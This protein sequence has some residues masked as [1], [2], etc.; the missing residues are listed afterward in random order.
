M[1]EGSIRPPRAERRLRDPARTR[2][3]ILSTAAAEF[4]RHGFGGGRV[5]RIARRARAN[6]RMIYHYF[7]NKDGLYLAVLERVYAAKR[8]AERALEVDH[9]DPEAA[10]RALVDFNFAY[11]QDHPEF[12]AL[13]N[14]EN[15]QRARHL[16]R[17]RL[18]KDLYSPVVETLRTV[19]REGV[20][21]GM[22]RNDVDPVHLYITIVGLPY[23]Y[24]G[25]N[26]TLSTIFDRSLAA[27]AE[28]ARYRAHAG[29]VML[30]FLRAPARAGRSQV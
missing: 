13:L 21:R 10:I 11:C 30:G 2:G 27:A 25:N 20:R 7:G 24:V 5:D 3:A 15:L 14:D 22:F 16:S 29:D 4:A 19:L 28:I 6:K 18:V 12:Q 17:S 8:T 9:R 1:P 26:A 23:F